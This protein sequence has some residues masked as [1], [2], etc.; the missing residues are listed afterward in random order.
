M[1]CGIKYSHDQIL[2]SVLR[3][4]MAVTKYVPTIK[5]HLSAAVTVATRSWLMEELVWM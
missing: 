5:G 2:M 1:T 3:T 4:L